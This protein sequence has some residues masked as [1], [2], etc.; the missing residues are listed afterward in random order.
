[1]G[2]RKIVVPQVS[3]QETAPSVCLA[4]QKLLDIAAVLRQIIQHGMAIIH[5]MEPKDVVKL[6]EKSL[7]LL[8]EIEGKIKRGSESTTN[9]IT[10]NTITAEEREK[11][12]IDMA[13]K[14]IEING[15]PSIRFIPNN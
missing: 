2:R 10:F 6:M 9:A 15:R 13:S 3:T 14:G 4:D 12:L 8:A 5:E 11:R 7:P 1:M